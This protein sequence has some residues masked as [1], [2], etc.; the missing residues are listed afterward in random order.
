MK[1]Y[2]GLEVSVKKARAT[3]VD[4]SREH[5]TVSVKEQVTGAVPLLGS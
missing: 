3:I 2:A 1:N 5:R 4:E